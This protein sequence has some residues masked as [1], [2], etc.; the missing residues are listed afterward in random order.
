MVVTQENFV[1]L[2]HIL[3]KLVVFPVYDCLGY[4]YTWFMWVS[5]KSVWAGH[6]AVQDT[7]IKSL[8]TGKCYMSINI[9]M[10]CYL[11]S[12][13]LHIE[14]ILIFINNLQWLQKFPKRLSDLN[15]H[16]TFPL[17]KPWGDTYDFEWHCF[18]TRLWRHQMYFTL[19]LN[20]NH[21]GDCSTFCLP[22]S[23]NVIDQLHATLLTFPSGSAESL[24]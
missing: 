5:C 2:I 20:C 21:F 3:R 10:T 1:S 16:L 17:M 4:Y 7:L 9:Q 12:W 14:G 22:L 6:L 8:L 18:Q 15:D 24:L 13:F 11:A 19:G 23:Q